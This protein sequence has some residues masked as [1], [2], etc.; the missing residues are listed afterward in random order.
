[1]I[2][3]K[4]N[5]MAEADIFQAMLALTEETLTASDFI[6]TTDGDV[7][8][9]EHGKKILENNHKAMV[10]AQIAKNA[11]AINREVLEA[12]FAGSDARQLDCGDFSLKYKPESTY[13][14]FDAKAYKAAHPEDYDRYITESTRKGSVTVDFND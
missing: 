10:L 3:T 9:T 1:M 7:I 13:K 12:V 5:A 6:H 2:Y 8:I 4:N 14:R 11:D